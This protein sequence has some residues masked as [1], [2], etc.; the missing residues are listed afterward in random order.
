MDYETLTAQSKLNAYVEAEEMNLFVLLK[1]KLFQDGNQFCVMLGEDIQSAICGF[2]DTPRK[3]V[4]AFNKEWDKAAVV[5]NASLSGE[6]NGQAHTMTITPGEGV[7][8][9]EIGHWYSQERVAMLIE[10]EREATIA[11]LKRLRTALAEI[12]NLDYTRAATNSCAYYANKIAVEALSPN[13]S[14]SG[15]PKS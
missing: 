15:E 6:N 3:A 13:S 12:S 4:W 10:A 11:E 9:E 1:P 2:G 8:A 7:N 5:P 14:L